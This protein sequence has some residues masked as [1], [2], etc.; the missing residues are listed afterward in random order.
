MSE[1]PALKNCAQQLYELQLLHFEKE[2]RIA[3]LE[4][5]LARTRRDSERLNWLES[6]PTIHM[7]IPVGRFRNNGKG[8]FTVHCGGREG[9]GLSIRAAIDAAAE[10]KR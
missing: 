10:V 7:T 6:G 9:K 3:L 8:I 1:N 4:A 2:N 5:E